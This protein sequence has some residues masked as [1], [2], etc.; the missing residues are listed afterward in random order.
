MRNC[1]VVCSLPG[2]ESAAFQPFTNVI[3]NVPNDGL[4]I[5]LTC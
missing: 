5:E 4:L 1:R 2:C 3:S